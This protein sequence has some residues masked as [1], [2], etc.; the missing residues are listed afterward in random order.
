MNDLVDR[1]TEL[2]FLLTFRGL[3]H[4]NPT[5]PDWTFNT[6]GLRFTFFVGGHAVNKSAVSQR[7]G[8]EGDERRNKLAQRDW[9]GTHAQYE[10]NMDTTA[11]SLG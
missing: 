7:W 3:L 2:N 1:I 5:P 6:H 11:Q 9:Q 8:M 4:N 10:H